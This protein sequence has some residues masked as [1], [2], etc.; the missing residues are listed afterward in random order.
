[1][2]RELARRIFDLLLDSPNDFAEAE[3]ALRA[4]ATDE[5]ELTAAMRRFKNAG[6]GLTL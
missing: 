1:M 2:R 5:A 6:G 3:R 4:I